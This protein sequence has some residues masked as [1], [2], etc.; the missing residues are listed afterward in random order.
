VTHVFFHEFGVHQFRKPLLREFPEGVPE[1]LPQGVPSVLAIISN[2]DFSMVAYKSHHLSLATK[3][4]R[5]VFPIALIACPKI[6][7]L[8]YH[9]FPL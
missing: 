6:H 3:E 5:F 4:N 7:P 9:H 1:Y 2:P 8:V